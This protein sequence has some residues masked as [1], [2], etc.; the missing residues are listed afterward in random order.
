MIKVQVIDEFTL[1]KFNELKNIERARIDVKGKLFIGD[2]FECSKEMCDYLL[3]NNHL[4]KAVVKVI[5]VAPEEVKKEETIE[6]KEEKAEHEADLYKKVS[7]K[8]KKSSK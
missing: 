3:G 5:E 2:K 1:E 8:K 7:K 6:I 4:N